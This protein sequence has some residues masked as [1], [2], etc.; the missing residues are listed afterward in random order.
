MSLNVLFFIITLILGVV[1]GYGAISVIEKGDL[2]GNYGRIF[3]AGLLAVI[4]ILMFFES[5]SYIF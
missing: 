4:S 2:K 1:F 5:V 3:V